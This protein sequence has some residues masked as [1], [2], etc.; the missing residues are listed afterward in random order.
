[1]RRLDAESDQL[2]ARLE[3]ADGRDQGIKENIGLAVNEGI[4]QL[5]HLVELLAV[6]IVD[7]DRQLQC[8]GRQRVASRE[9]A[10]HMLQITDRA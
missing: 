6:E 2:P 5:H 3:P 10:H 8:K 1:M 7:L 9:H 4:E